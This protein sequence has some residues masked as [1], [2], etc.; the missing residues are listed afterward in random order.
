IA[1][2][3][4]ARQITPAGPLTLAVRPSMVNCASPS[5]MT[6][7]SSTTLWKWWPMPAPGGITPRCRK[8]NSGVTA[9]RFRSDVNPI[10]PAPPCT[11]DDCRNAAASVW[12][13]RSARVA[14]CAIGAVGHS[15]IRPMPS[16]T[17]TTSVLLRTV[18]SILRSVHGTRM[19]KPAHS[20]LDRPDRRLAH[21]VEHIVVGTAEGDA[22]GILRHPDR[23]R[24]RPVGEKHLHAASGSDIV[25][26][27]GVHRCSVGAR[28]DAVG[29]I[30]G[31]EHCRSQVQHPELP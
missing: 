16:R 24:I 1:W 21:H 6:N 25:A 8:L 27:I 19:T 26:A 20:G 15:G 9:P 10:L 5:R 7:I 23:A 31:L 11:A 3:C 17:A 30:S 2:E 14:C 29:G 18:M 22:D 28:I 13:I 12:T 4:P